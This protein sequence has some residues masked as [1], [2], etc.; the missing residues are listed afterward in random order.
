[1]PEKSTPLES[2]V[3]EYIAFLVSSALRLYEEPV[4]GSLRLLDA[5]RRFINLVLAHGMIKDAALVN[6]LR[7][8]LEK[9]DWGISNLWRDPVKLREFLAELNVELAGKYLGLLEH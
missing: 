9:I 2:D 7:T 1:M 6:E 3:Y 8:L 5:A 4:Y